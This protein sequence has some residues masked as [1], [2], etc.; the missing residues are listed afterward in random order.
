MV[1]C[2]L[3]SVGVV[4]LQHYQWRRDAGTAFVDLQY[5]QHW[6]L[7]GG[8]YALIAL[9]IYST[10]LSCL[11]R[12]GTL[13]M[14]VQKVFSK[15]WRHENQVTCSFDP[16]HFDNCSGT[17][18][19][20]WIMVLFYALLLVLAAQVLLN[21][22]EKLRFYESL[23]IVISNTLVSVVL[24]GLAFSLIVPVFVGLPVLSLHLAMREFRWNEF[25]KLSGLWDRHKKAMYAKLESGILSLTESET[26][27]SLMVFWDELAKM[28]LW[29]FDLKIVFY[30][31]SSHAVPFLVLVLPWLQKQLGLQF[32]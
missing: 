27:R 19:L 28:R 11:F 31:V 17:R 29:P 14:F 8:Y 12:G 6:S 23:A 13:L 18:W 7:T 5:P 30:F 20:G 2:F 10:I 3:V 22:V 16:T 26:Y 32:R 21:L 15:K 9:F 25:T 4:L 24:F 1:L